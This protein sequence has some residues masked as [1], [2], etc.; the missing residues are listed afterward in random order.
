M[1]PE[2]TFEQSQRSEFPSTATITCSPL[3]RDRTPSSSP[4]YLSWYHDFRTLDDKF[5]LRHSSLDAYLYLRYLKMTVA[6]CLVGCLLTWPILFP[7]NATGGDDALQLDVIAIGNIKGTKRLYAHTVIAWVFLG[8]VMLLITR[9]RLF[10][11]NIRQA[12]ASI[13][14]NALRLSSRT[15]LLLGVPQEALGDSNLHKFFGS[16]AQRSW[17][18]P[19]ATD[20]EKLVGQR[21][22]TVDTLETAEL[23][24]QQNVRKEI[25][26]SGADSSTS[27]AKLV[28]GNVRP[29]HRHYVV[30]SPIDTITTSRDELNDLASRIQSIRE[31]HFEDL[32]QDSQAIFVEY[33]DQASAHEAYQQVRHRSPLSLQPRYTNVQPKEVLWPNL[34]LDPSV[35]I[36]Y[37]YMALIV[38]IATIIFWS[39]PV[40]LA[41]TLSNVDHLTSRFKWLRWINKLPDLVLGFLKGFVPPFVVSYVVSYVPYFFRHVAK[42][43]QPTNVE[44]EKM[45]QRWFMAFQVIQVFLLTT[46]T[47]GAAAVAQKIANDPASLPIR[48]AKNLPMASNFYLSYF[49]IQGIGSAAKDILDYSELFEYIFYDGVFDRTPRQKYTRITSMKGIGWG[50]KYPKF[51]NFAIIAIAY[52]C[53]APLVL[54]FA[55]AG[56]YFFYLSSK[57]NLL[58]RIQVKVEPRG[59]CYSMALQHLIIGV[60]L[61]ELCLLGLFS[62]KAA[63]GPIIMMA[64]LL[65][66]TVIYHVTV[67]RYLGPLESFLPLDVLDSDESEPLL[68][69]EEGE[70]R[71]RVKKYGKKLPKQLLDPLAVFLEP[72]IFASTEA[73]RPWLKD[74]EDEDDVPEYSEEELKNAYLNP[75]LTSKTPKLWIPKDQHGVAAKE[76][77]ANK[78]AGL[79]T[80][81]EGA[82]LDGKGRLIWDKDDFSK[83]PVFKIAKRF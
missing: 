72:H 13:K 80:T 79:V 74:P 7:I 14:Q 37:S 2:P 6:M 42:A 25:S 4:S 22:G 76:I 61:S 57:L 29:S 28:E 36:T 78:A 73:L 3:P 55:A 54:G 12:H 27:A 64:I 65:I 35:R 11:I 59:A 75:A 30:G 8:F 66:G 53:I 24:L 47:S 70:S 23:K 46:F 71:S 69:A 39:I 77:E 1:H 58:Y 33:R 34:N 21:G 16:G 40:G 81:D 49:I 44:A 10:A 48:L 20:L 26:K 52:S 18:V 41:G 83:T 62:I 43:Y 17:P 60:Y 67:N 9:E 50:S 19:K 63:T 51:A 32:T 31:S 5:L 56:L 45:V 68:A 15:I 82:E 38:V